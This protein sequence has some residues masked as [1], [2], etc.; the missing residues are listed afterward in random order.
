[1]RKAEIATPAAPTVVRDDGSGEHQYAIIAVGVQGRRTAVSRTT[2]AGGLAKLRWDSVVGADA[3][4]VVR[5]G[6][7]ITG[8]LRIEGSNKE[9]T[10]K[11][12][13]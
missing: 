13:K 1:M 4:V 7:E 3:Y 12:P 6:K 9:W 2:K 8:P 11:A 5:D 10:D